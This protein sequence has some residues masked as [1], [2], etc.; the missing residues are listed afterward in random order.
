MWERIVTVDR[1]YKMCAFIIQVVSAAG[2][3]KKL[4][5]KTFPTF[6]NITRKEG[7]VLFNDALGTFYLRLYGIRHMVKN[8]SYR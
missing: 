3:E 5:N 2:V 7:N 6:L 1:L 8:H 4:M